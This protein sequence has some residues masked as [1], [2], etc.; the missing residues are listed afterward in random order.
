MWSGIRV[1]TKDVGEVILT[2]KM[3]FNGPAKPVGA[4]RPVLPIDNALN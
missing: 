4:E 3:V 2:K 1:P